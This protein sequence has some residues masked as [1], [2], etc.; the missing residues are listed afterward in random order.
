MQLRQLCWLMSWKGHDTEL[1]VGAWQ[2]MQS[3]HAQLAFSINDRT[4]FLLGHELRQMAHMMDVLEEPWTRMF[5]CAS[6]T[7]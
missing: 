7:A 1:R 4:L 6:Y 3:L 2:S 5:S